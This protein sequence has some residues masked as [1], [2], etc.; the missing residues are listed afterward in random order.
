MFR[1]K[2]S[3]PCV[4]AAGRQ[5]ARHVAQAGFALIEALV[6]LAVAAVCLSAIGTLMA[7][8]SRTVRQVDQRLALV[9]TLRKVETALPDRSQLAD[10]QLSGEMAGS[11]WAISATPYLGASLR[12]P[13]KAP[14]AWLPQ[15][16][17]IKVRGPS[18]SLVEV[19]TL[20]LVPRGAT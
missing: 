14:P 9:S 17:L 13:S 4:A 15:S 6:T 16:V 19:E 20:R 12:S 2:P 1:R 10:A 7:K 5:S 8:N 3:E 18:G 11:A